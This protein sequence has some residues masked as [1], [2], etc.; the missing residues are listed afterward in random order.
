M[1]TCGTTPPRPR[2]GRVDRHGGFDQDVVGGLGPDEWVLAN[3]P[4]VD[5]LTDLDPEVADVPAGAAVHGF[6]FDHSEP[7]LD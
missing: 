6:A 1:S 7:D 4:A 3:I 5:E 2:R